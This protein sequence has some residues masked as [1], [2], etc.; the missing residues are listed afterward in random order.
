MFAC[1]YWS[2]NCSSIILTRQT[3]M[4]NTTNRQD[5]EKE[6]A[7]VSVLNRHRAVFYISNLRLYEIGKFKSLILLFTWNL[8]FRPTPSQK[9]CSNHVVGK[10]SEKIHSPF[11]YLFF[12]LKD[13]DIKLPDSLSWNVTNGHG[14]IQPTVYPFLCKNDKS[15]A[16]VQC[17]GLHN[18]C[19]TL[20]NTIRTPNVSFMQ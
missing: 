19:A 5:H 16:S 14:H 13:I 3:D 10:Q 15:S 2:P 12:K 6:Q 9:L 1:C 7:C 11:I 17:T 8:A 20:H 4:S 18:V